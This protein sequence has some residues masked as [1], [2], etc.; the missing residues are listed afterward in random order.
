[1]Y[2]E[3]KKLTKGKCDKVIDLFIGKPDAT[4]EDI[5]E[6]LNSDDKEKEPANNYTTMKKM[7]KEQLAEYLFENLSRF[8][9]AGDILSFLC[10]KEV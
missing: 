2:N 1:V 8:T 5:D 7:S 4:A 10:E 9:S 6:C 3:D